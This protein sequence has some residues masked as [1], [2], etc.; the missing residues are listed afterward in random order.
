[1][2][3]IELVSLPKKVLYETARNHQPVYPT[4]NF[5][6]RSGAFVARGLCSSRC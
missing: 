6:R 4:R 1:M 3:T 5:G 2:R